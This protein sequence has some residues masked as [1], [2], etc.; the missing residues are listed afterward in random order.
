MYARLPVVAVPIAGVTEMVDSNSAFLAVV[1]TRAGLADALRAAAK[2]EQF[3]NKIAA[4]ARTRFD[5]KMSS[6]SY[7]ASVLRFLDRIVQAN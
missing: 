2:S 7:S 3:R 1:R 4:A 6:R 5:R